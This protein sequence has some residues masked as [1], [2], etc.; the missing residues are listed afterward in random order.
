[1]AAKQQKLIEKSNRC[2]LWPTLGSSSFRV[3]WTISCKW[4]SNRHKTERFS[5]QFTKW[6]NFSFLFFNFSIG[7]PLLL[8]VDINDLPYCLRSF[9][10][11]LLM[12]HPVFSEVFN[13]MGSHEP[14]TLIKLTLGSINEKYE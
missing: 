1:M 7:G 4:F 6:Y 12:V 3:S 8:L 9:C 5:S 2:W 10:K 13:I 11:T 14:V